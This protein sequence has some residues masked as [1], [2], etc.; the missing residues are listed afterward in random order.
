MDTSIH[1]GMQG[2]SAAA[3]TWSQTSL[4]SGVE[5]YLYQRL[6]RSEIPG[7]LGAA[8]VSFPRH[9][10]GEGGLPQTSVVNVTQIATVDRDG[11]LWFGAPTIPMSSGTSS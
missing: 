7:D 5:S 9:E 3:A 4:V 2:S 8:G 1:T 11:G 6:V 10:Q